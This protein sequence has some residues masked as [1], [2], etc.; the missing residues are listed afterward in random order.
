MPAPPPPSPP[1][2][3]RVFRQPLASLVGLLGERVIVVDDGLA[4]VE[5]TGIT[6]DSRA[7]RPGDLYAALPGSQAH[8]AE[9]ASAAASAGAVAALTD[10]AGAER[11]RAAGLA[12]LAV[13][14]PRAVLGTAAAWVYGDPAADLLLIGVTGTNGKTTTAYLLE[15]GMR[16]AGRRTGLIGTIETRIGDE[17]LPSARTTPE[18]TDLQALFAVMRERGVDAVAME[19]SSIALAMGRVDGTVFDLAAFTNFSQDHLDFHA[20]MED[21]F[22]AKASLFTP[23]RARRGV[24]DVDDAYGARLARE[25]GV[26]VTT[27]S[28]CGDPAADWRAGAVDPQPTGATGFHVSGPGGVEADALVRLPGRFNVDNALL[29]I[30]AL[31]TAGLDPAAAARGVADCTT[32]PGRM[33]RVRCGQDFLAVVDYAHTPDAVATLLAA[34]RPAP[35][36]RLIAV[37]GCGGDRDRSKRPLMGEVAARAADLLV[38]TDDNPRSEDPAGIR[39]A[40]VA[41]AR[42]VPTGD[43]GEVVEVADRREAIAVAVRAARAGDTVVVAGKGHEQG[44]EYADRTL[45]FDDRAVL[46]DLLAGAGAPA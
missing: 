45:P 44:Q 9:F 26:P 22:A 23:R 46:R 43:R 20:D 27:V 31:A 11:C 18:A 21:Y 40:V 34:L 3:Q 30:A 12:V 1:R 4:D 38:V 17:A 33:E 10:P 29:A 8:G 7:V 24:V 36:A 42:G 19:V 13:D 28:P 41:G 37:L 6:H 32:V 39:A 35:P 15:A 14:L 16:A 25:A 2:P 5:V